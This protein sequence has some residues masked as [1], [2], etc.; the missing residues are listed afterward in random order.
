MLVIPAIDI[1]GG[2]CVRLAQGQMARETVYSENPIEIAIRWKEAGAEKI[3]LVDLEG[4]VGGRPAN[5]ETIERITRNLSI[6]IQLGGGIRDL[7]TVEAYLNLGI[8]EVIL[9]TVAVKHPE[10]VEKVCRR[11][12]G[13]VIVGIDARDNCVAVEGWTEETKLHPL[14]LAQ[15]FE[16]TGVSAIIYTDIYRDGMHTGPNV[17]ATRDLAKTLYIP[18]I[19]SGGISTIEDVKNLLKIEDDGVTGMITGR[20]LYDGTLDLS[21]AIKWAKLQ[22]RS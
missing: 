11:F 2:R 9:G 16:Q 1:K 10:F 5:R 19:A 18:V 12:P 13:R 3:H 15:R 4:A 6:P 8:Q 22:K 14:E 20:A 21:E 17:E 7:A